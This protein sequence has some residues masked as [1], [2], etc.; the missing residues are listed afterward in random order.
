MYVYNITQK[1]LKPHK[2]FRYYLVWGTW[3]SIPNKIS[4]LKSK[5]LIR[6]QS[7][8]R[9][10]CTILP[11]RTTWSYKSGSTI[12]CHGVLPDPIIIYYMILPR[13]TT[14]S[15]KSVLHIL[16]RRTIRSHKSVLHIMPRRTTQSHKNTA[17]AFSPIA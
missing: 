12:S 13:R 11:R 17:E 1:I 4:Y 16:P 10:S 8:Y 6:M 5:R 7:F 15:Y 3:G 14:R 9:I 2:K